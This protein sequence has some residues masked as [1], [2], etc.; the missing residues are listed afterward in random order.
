MKSIQISSKKST[1]QNLH[2]LFIITIPRRFRYFPMDEILLQRHRSIL[3][4]PDSA[5]GGASGGC[6]AEAQAEKHLNMGAI[7]HGDTSNG[8]NSG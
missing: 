3:E 4:S 5:G 1:D 8:L 6:C 7:K 2:F